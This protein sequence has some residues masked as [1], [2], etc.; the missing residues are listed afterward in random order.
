MA[1]PEVQRA[2][3]RGYELAF[4]LGRHRTVIECP[5]SAII[6]ALPVTSHLA[7]QPAGVLARL[8][9][10]SQLSPKRAQ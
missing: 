6:E 1:E 9:S 5:K 3:R 4:E 8:E 10:V 2:F 7:G